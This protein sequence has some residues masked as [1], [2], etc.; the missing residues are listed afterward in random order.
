MSNIDVA[1]AEV[2]A[3]ATAIIRAGGSAT[4]AE[5][6]AESGL[7]GGLVR[8]RL[9]RNGPSQQKREFRWFSRHGDVWSVTI[10]GKSLIDG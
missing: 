6:V 4:I 10:H 5:V 7:P 2:R 1:V 9:L 8:R 3:I